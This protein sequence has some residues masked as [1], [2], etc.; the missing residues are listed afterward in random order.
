MSSKLCISS[1]SVLVA[2][3]G[4][5]LIAAAA[6]GSGGVV[7]ITFGD[8]TQGPAP[9]TAAGP[10]VLSTNWNNV[11]VH[12]WIWTSGHDPEN[13]HYWWIVSK[14]DGNGPGLAYPTGLATD[15][16]SVDGTGTPLVQNM[17]IFLHDP[18]AVQSYNS[19]GG[20]PYW[21]TESTGNSAVYATQQVTY[22]TANQYGQTDSSTITISNIPYSSYTLYVGG[23]GLWL[24]GTAI[25]GD[26]VFTD[27]TTSSL[28]FSTVYPNPGSGAA[29]S[30]A[31]LQFVEGGVGPGWPDYL[32]GDFNL[33]GEV[34]PEDFGIL[35]DGFGLD[36]LPFGK[37]ESWTLGD[38]N[39]DGEIGP[40]DFGLLKD[41]FGL[42]GGPTGTYPLANV[43]EPTTLSLLA[44][45]GLL[46]AR[47]NRRAK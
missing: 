2:V 1:R 46:A 20:L 21:S 19:Y 3:V 26:A 38:A 32:P 37:H 8:G 10:V 7:G 27:L 34:G 15:I 36:G 6:Q 24:N 22:H 41:N 47:K 16:A 9:A 11:A 33:D 17:Q 5:L 18:G 28:V 44:L 42:D 14:G 30:L 13:G 12:P 39:D 43:P 25:S 23:S 40:E 29:G 35:K 31:Y 45:G 4:V